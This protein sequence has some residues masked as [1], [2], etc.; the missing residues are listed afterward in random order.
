MSHPR[1]G[2]GDF[3]RA[4]RDA[5]TPAEAGIE[6]FPGARRV[7][8]LRREELAVLA[9]LSPDYLRRLEQG[10]QANVSDQVL[11]ALA[12]ALRLDD[13]ERAHLH[14]LAAPLDARRA[15]SAGAAQQAAPGLLRVMGELEHV[16]VLLLGRRAEVLARNALL[17]AVLGT[18]LPPGE[19]FVRYLFQDPRARDRIENWETFAAAAI[20]G[21]RR[22][23]GLFPDDRLLQEL[24]EQ[25]CAADA[26]AARWWADHRVRDFASTEKRIRHPLAGPLRFVIEVLA[27]PYQPDQQLVVYTAEPD[28]PTARTLPLLAS[29]A[30]EGRM[31]PSRPG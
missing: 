23:A 24:I 8:G 6:G 25:L 28:S 26:D 20:G 27:A 31:T 9:G 19:S 1:P 2:L 5:I 30:G 29:W 10:R 12:R 13:T 18:S 14:R 3:L 11:D 7:P 16:P 4:R 17:V 15:R 21:L 22:M